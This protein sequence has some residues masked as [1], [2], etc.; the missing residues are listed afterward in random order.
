MPLYELLLKYGGPWITVLL[1]LISI[2]FAQLSEIK[3]TA[4][5]WVEAISQ[6]W[7]MN[8]A[9]GLAVVSWIVAYWRLFKG[10]VYLPA[11]GSF[12]EFSTLLLGLII[13]L[14]ALAWRAISW[15][16]L[17]PR[18]RL[19]I[20]H[21]LVMV[22]IVSSAGGLLRG[23]PEEPLSQENGK[24]DRPAVA[25]VQARLKQLGCFRAIG[26]SEWKK[27]AFQT[28]DELERKDGTFNAITTSAVLS[29]QMANGTLTS[30]GMGK[31]QHEEFR[32]LARPF[33]FLKGGP[34]RC[35]EPPASAREP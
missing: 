33:P 10:Y 27:G 25:F 13:I 18:L 14:A 2:A 17:P 7:L 30:D 32:L 12:S 1:I 28:V 35:P 19:W 6:K 29:F 8:T 20:T 21:G 15:S 24:N 26:V 3:E 34:E 5:R 16:R 4:Q 31:I 9:V 23:E 11:A 22:L